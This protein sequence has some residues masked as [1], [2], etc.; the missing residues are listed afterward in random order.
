MQYQKVQSV[1]KRIQT[2]GDALDKV[3]LDTMQTISEAVGATLGPGGRQVLIE[4]QEHNLPPMITKDGV[5][6]FRS[7]G[8]RNPAAH[9]VMEAARDASV[10]TASEAGDGTTTATILAEVVV[11]LTKKY[12]KANPRVSPQRVVRR[13][14]ELFKTDIEP[15][16]RRLST[17]ADMTT[18]GGRAML[19]HV[20]KVSAN[21]DMDLAAAVIECFDLV[22]DD[23]NVTIAESSGPSKY[24]VERIEGFPIHMGYEESAGKFYPKFV[25]DPGN[26]RVLLEKP[27]FVLYHGRI[28]DP[29]S[30]FLLMSKLGNAFEQGQI[31]PNIVLA[32][33]GFSES[34]IGWLS[35][36][37]AEPTALNVFPLLVPQSPF[38]NGQFDFLQDLAAVTGGIVVDPTN[39]S[40]ETVNLDHLGHA[41]MFEAYRF[42]ANV[43][44]KP[45][46]ENHETDLLLRVDQLKTNLSRAESQL[47]AMHLQE[48]IAKLTGGIARLKVI[49]VSNGELKEKRD[50]AEDA[51]CAVR[52][53]IKHG[54]LP[55]GA[56]TLLYL[57]E[58]LLMQFPGDEVV[59]QVLVPALFE[60]FKRL[61]ENSGISAENNPEEFAAILTPIVERVFPIRRVGEPRMVGETECVSDY[62]R[63]TPLVYDAL[64]CKHVDP[65]EGGILDSTP[66]VLE[67]IRNS[68]SIASLLGTLGGTVV[69]ERNAEVEKQEARDMANFQRDANRNEAD[70]RP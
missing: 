33:T 54:C 61:L 43:V 9:C 46:D 48:R 36:M 10:R 22:G 27:V 44:G 42:R 60:P 56:W 12:T 66:A 63:V 17:K 4:R 53:A 64:E 45:R 40:F 7:L 2:Q 1:A 65:F 37:F 25:N 6:V 19:Q 30:L 11:R 23:G 35:M 49:G 51:V 67:A 50:R 58:K 8:F 41:S 18:P 68:L 28:Q 5:T 24:E 20:A 29:Q 13:L 69:F 21:G 62:E 57:R 15:T 39:F 52:G 47:D 55:G 70:E 3:V 38:A 32:A 59:C 31:S 26:Q 34:V 16:I 14:E